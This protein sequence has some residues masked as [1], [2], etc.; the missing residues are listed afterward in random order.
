[1]LN[2][3]TLLCAVPNF[4]ASRIM[5]K[6][7]ILTLMTLLLPECLGSI[8]QQQQEEEVI[9]IGNEWLDKTILGLLD[10]IHPG[11]VNRE[12]CTAISLR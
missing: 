1:M 10:L 4:F 3:T 11:K 9:R 8:Q 12:Y 2:M 7:L 6:P 5:M